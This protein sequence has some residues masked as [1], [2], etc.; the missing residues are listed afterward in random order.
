MQAVQTTSKKGKTWEVLGKH[1][2]S[3]YS[4]GISQV[5]KIRNGKSCSNT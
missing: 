1:V 2:I 4:N 3:L 5:V